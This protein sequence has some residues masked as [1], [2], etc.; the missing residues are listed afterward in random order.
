[1]T[2][3]QRGNLRYI[4][5]LTIH[6]DG[7]RILKVPINLE[8]LLTLDRGRAYVGFTGATGAAYQEHSIIN[9]RFN[10]SRSGTLSEPANLHSGRG[11]RRYGTL[12][13]MMARR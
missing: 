9:W 4:G 11:C 2:T 6:L 10:E 7:R 12:Q 5:M 3:A 8:E 1:M 13:A